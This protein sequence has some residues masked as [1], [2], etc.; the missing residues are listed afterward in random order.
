MYK[1]TLWS[2]FAVLLLALAGCSKDEPTPVGPVTNDQ[3]QKKVETPPIS[4]WSESDIAEWATAE[5]YIKTYPP[6]AKK[7][8][9]GKTLADPPIVTN[10]GF[11]DGFNGW[12]TFVT[13]PGM[14]DYSVSPPAA[15]P[16]WAWIVGATD[17][18]G[19]NTAIYRSGMLH[20]EPLAHSGNA[21]ASAVENVGGIVHRLYQIITIPQPPTG[22]NLKL[23]FWIRWKNQYIGIPDPTIKWIDGIQDIIVSLRGRPNGAPPAVL[24]KAFTLNLPPFSGGGNIITANYEAWTADVTAFAGETDTL[25]FETDAKGAALFVDLDDIRI[26][27]PPVANAGPDQTVPPTEPSGATVTLDGSGSSDPDGDDLKYQWTWTGGSATGKQPTITLPLGSHDITLT[28]NDGSQVNASATDKVVVNVLSNRPP[29][30]NAGPDQTVECTTHSGAPVTLDGSGSSDADGDPLTY[31]WAWTGGSAAGLTP[32]VT[33]PLGSHEIT[34]TVDDGKGGTSTDKVTVN[35]VDT[36]PPVINLNGPNEIT[37]ECPGT[38]RDPTTVTDACDP[39][40]TLTTEGTVDGHTLGTYTLKYT[41]KDA[42]GNQLTATRTVKV[43]DTTPPSITLKGSNPIILECPATYNEPGAVVT[44][45]CDP[46]PTL[47]IGGTVDAGTLGTY[48]V[49]YTATDHSGNSATATRTVIVQ[50]TKAPTLSCSVSTPSLWPPNNKFVNVGLRVNVKDACDPNPKVNIKVYSDEDN[51]KE[52]GDDNGKDDDNEKGKD[53]DK[54]KG[55]DKDSPD[56]KDI[57]AGT[58]QLRAERS[59]KGDGRVYLI[60]V[61]ATDKS[62]NTSFS[63]CTVVVPHSESKKA[64]ADVN[65]QAAAA[66][67]SCGPNGSPLTPFLIGSNQ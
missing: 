47:T 13:P 12:T 56:A 51:D 45:A 6:P 55:D 49:K 4:Y 52:K 10:G 61:T 44:D 1:S 18:F 36:T 62:G 37:L 35:V 34:L 53:K 46:S 41:A 32:T 59:G 29:I 48:T 23:E 40:P 8:R 57:G 16:E 39:L 67:A 33:L 30:A 50:D 22:G 9:L 28:V 5:P 26:N 58:L 24:F 27:R 65:A 64:I 14:R 60:V 20:P 17:P 2:I 43:V 25:D 7:G 21:G 42:S 15:H 38:Y 19:T 31:T 54:G 66:K 63:S 11:E 3:P